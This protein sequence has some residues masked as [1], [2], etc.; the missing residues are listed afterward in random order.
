ME[1]VQVPWEAMRE[2]SED[3]YRM[4]DFFERDGYQADIAAL[5]AEYPA[6]HTFERWLAEGGL[7]QMHRAV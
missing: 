4:Y 6:L 5:R 3:L 7:S 2:Q 1:Y